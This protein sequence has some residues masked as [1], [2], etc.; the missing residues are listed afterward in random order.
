MIATVSFT[1][2]APSALSAWCYASPGSRRWPT[3]CASAVWG[4]SAGIAML[5]FLLLE[6]P[7]QRRYAQVLFLALVAIG[8]LGVVAPPIRSLLF[9]AG[10]RRGAAMARSSSR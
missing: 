5:L 3:A 1:E 2:S 8:M 10:W 4:K 7:N 9:F 6:F